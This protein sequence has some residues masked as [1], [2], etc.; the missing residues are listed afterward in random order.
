MKSI[1]S[2]VLHS[3]QRCN[4]ARIWV[5]ST[6]VALLAGHDYCEMMNCTKQSDLQVAFALH[7]EDSSKRGHGD[8]NAS[9]LMS[10]Q[11]RA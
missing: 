6:K 8:E 2:C 3:L 5:Q 7:S 4:V 11:C 1:M 9:F 10:V